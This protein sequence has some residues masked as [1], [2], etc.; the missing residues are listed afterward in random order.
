MTVTEPIFTKL[1]IAGQITVKKGNV[2]AEFSVC[3]TNGLF[4]GTR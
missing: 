2:Y 3:L 1:G 4:V